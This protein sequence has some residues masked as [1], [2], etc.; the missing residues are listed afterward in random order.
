MTAT[1][2]RSSCEQGE[3]VLFP[4]FLKLADRRC[5]VVGA[6][7][8]AELK[9]ESLLM[10]EARIHVVAPRATASVRRLA[11]DGRILWA[12]R[13]F[14]PMDLHGVSL[15]IAA[16]GCSTVNRSVYEE[17]RT[18]GIFCNSVDDPEHCDFYCSAVVR[19]GP[20]QIAISTG[21]NSPA[22]GQRLR[23]ELEEQ[24]SPEYEGWVRSLG[25][26]R[27]SLFARTLPPH[28]RRNWLHTIASD[29][30]FQKF[31]RRGRRLPG[32]ALSS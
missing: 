12:P 25:E 30:S 4:L 28:Q 16:T 6:G 14:E 22:L 19:R 2:W 10:A 1:N 5:L 7:T 13:S 27:S 11:T 21:G 18:R 23:R 9:I 15:A 31:R 20:L 26:A 24:F 8:V 29:W 3:A 17:A 32:G